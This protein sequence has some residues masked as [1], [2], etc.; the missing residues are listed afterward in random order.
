[1]TRRLEELSDLVLYVAVPE[2]RGEGWA[3]EIS[4]IQA[5]YPAGAW[6]RAVLIHSAYPLSAILDNTREG[7]LS[8]PFVPTIEWETEEDLARVAQHLAVVLHDTG[9]LP[10]ATQRPGRLRI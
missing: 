1:M 3:S 8:E 7:H 5:R 10:S 4:D 2:G 6:K 9:R